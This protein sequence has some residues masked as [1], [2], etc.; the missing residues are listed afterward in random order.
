MTKS[1]IQW[2]DETWN[3]VAG[4]TKVSE[5]CRNCYAMGMSRRIAA[6][7]DA[8]AAKEGD[9]ALTE[10]Q[11]AYRQVVKREDGGLALP[12]WN[13]EV[14]CIESM[15]DAPL[16]WRKPRMVFVNSMGDLFHEDV[17]FD[18]IDRVFAVMALCPQHTFQVLTK[19]PDRMAY[20]FELFVGHDGCASEYVHD[21]FNELARDVWLDAGKEEGDVLADLLAYQ[22]PLPNVWLG[23]SVE[24]QKTAD[25]RIPHLLRC[26][27]AVRFFSCEPLHGGVDLGLDAWWHPKYDG[28]VPASTL[29][30]AKQLS[31][32]VHWIIVGGE[33][34]TGAR[35]CDVA[36]IRSIIAQCKDAGVP[37][38]VK[39]LG[40][41]PGI[42][43][44]GTN[45]YTR[46]CGFWPDNGYGVEN[47]WIVLI[48]NP[49]GGD[50]AEW[51]ED[52][53]VREMPWVM[54]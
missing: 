16:R 34:G 45:I 3:P 21:Q 24:D 15:L 6:S 32:I 19:R 23:C 36:W 27:A 37:C 41:E 44:D 38:F 11:A 25:E 30:G 48:T 50:M 46:R 10:K 1:K 33:S 26:P 9:G 12:Q 40:S 17:P 42:T 2:T 14:V 7:A 4:C 52:L 28:T 31:E 47:A 39:Q 29:P 35:P 49:K 13:N 20:Y 53:R 51:P 18:F 8:R 43:I 22:W 5:G 54:A